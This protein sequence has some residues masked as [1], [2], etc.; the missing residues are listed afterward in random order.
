MLFN[1]YGFLFLFLPVTLAGFFALGRHSHALAM[2]WLVAASLFFY[3]WWYPPYLALLLS[4]AVFNFG[5]GL[6]I[7]RSRAPVQRHRLL[8]LAVIGNLALLGYFKYAGFLVGVMGSSAVLGRSRSP[9]CRWASRSLAD[10]DRLSRR[11]RAR[12]GA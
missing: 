1:S 8:V 5:S 3:G 6:A 12:R 10:P 11:H 9:G 4:S 2:G 7:S